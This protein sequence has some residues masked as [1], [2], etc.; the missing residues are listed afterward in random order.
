MTIIWHEREKT[1]VYEFYSIEYCCMLCF[2]F[3]LFS[4]SLLG[5]NIKQNQRE[6]W[7]WRRSVCVRFVFE[8]YSPAKCYSLAFQIERNGLSTVRFFFCI[9]L[10][11][12]V[13]FSI[14]VKCARNATKILIHSSEQ[15]IGSCFS[16]GGENSFSVEHIFA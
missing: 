5:W 11:C 3:V 6:Y 1:T 4:D 7:T 2:F 10:M 8:C 9:I 13:P 14:E 12:V 16:L 15:T